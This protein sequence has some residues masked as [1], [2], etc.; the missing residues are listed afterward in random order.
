MLHDR[1]HWSSRLGFV[2]AAA[3]S[4]IGLGNLWKF[5]YITWDN[6]GGVFVLMYLVC[7]AAVGLPIMMAEILVGRST[8]RSV[9]GALKEAVGPA[10]GWV[11]GLGVLTGFVILGYYTVI[12]GWALRYFFDCLRWS[13]QGFDGAA[14][15]TNFG[16][17]VSDGSQQVMLAALFMLLTV[18]VVLRGISGGIE[19]AARI[20]MPTLFVILVLMLISAL[21]MEGAQEALAFMFTPDFSQFHAGSALEAL[22]Q[23]FFSLSLGMG[24]MITY[25]SYLSKEESVPK[26]AGIVVLLDTLIAIS[27]AVI[28]FAVI[29][30]VPGMKEAITGST[31]GM[32]F[33]TLPSLFY[34]EVP[35]GVLLAPLFYLL[36]CFAAL[37]STISL[38]EVVASYFIDER[39]WS[40]TRATITCGFGVFVLSLLCALSFGAWD[41][42]SSFTWVEGKNGLFSHLDY[43]A[44]NWF[45]TLGG[46]LITIAVGWVLSRSFTET[47]LTTPP[48]PGWFSY[49]AW[50]FFIRFLAPLAVAAIIV[51]VILGADFS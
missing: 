47:E 5:P 15:N 24:A 32:L 34:N 7:I 48:A 4:A 44:A 36:V 16:V 22:G 18:V 2:L 30:S 26:S 13:V 49:P 37:T 3:G 51:A 12:A 38:L 39:R 9:V 45:L 17:F 19:R 41:P 28:M 1:G 14:L 35:F 43:L 25:G 27:A 31:A 29:F 8:Q 20:L 50:L 23:A 40:R 11:G 10:W 6:G 33:I 46:L 42:L 21:S